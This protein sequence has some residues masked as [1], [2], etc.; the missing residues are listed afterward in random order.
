M[1]EYLAETRRMAS[2]LHQSIFE[3]RRARVLA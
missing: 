3:T 1:K 2:T